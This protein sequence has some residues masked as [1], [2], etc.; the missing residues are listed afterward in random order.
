[1]DKPDVRGMLT[2]IAKEICQPHRKRANAEQNDRH[3]RSNECDKERL[4]HPMHYDHASKGNPGEYTNVAG[5][6]RSQPLPQGS[7]HLFFAEQHTND[8]REIGSAQQSYVRNNPG[9]HSRATAAPPPEPNTI[10]N[11]VKCEGSK[12]HSP[13]RTPF[14]KFARKRLQSD[15]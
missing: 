10:T 9:Q 5:L 6:N 1:M 14:H 11:G 13:R 3:G 15:Q 8:I 7:N 4:Y 2:E 12:K